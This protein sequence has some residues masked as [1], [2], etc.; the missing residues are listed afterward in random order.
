MLLLMPGKVNKH[1]ELGG[2]SVITFFTLLA[3]VVIVVVMIDGRMARWMLHYA[4]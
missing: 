3:A 4:G 2:Q 1:T